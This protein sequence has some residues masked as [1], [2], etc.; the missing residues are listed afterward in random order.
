MRKIISAAAATLACV[1]AASAIDAQEWANYA[2]Y[3]S[4]NMSVEK[5]PVAVLMGDSITEGWFAQDPQFFMDNNFAGRGISGQVTPQMLLRFQRDVVELKPKFVVILAG[6]NDVARNSGAISPEDIMRNI[7]SMCEIA[8][9][10]KIRPVLCSVLP[11]CE[12]KWNPGIKDVAKQI[13]ELNALIKEYAKKNKI[14][15][16]DYHKEMADERG[17]LPPELSPDEVHPN[18]EGYKVMEGI[19]LKAL[20]KA[21]K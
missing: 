13:E 17:G 7:A 5:R 20:A 14:L 9:A 12:Y 11:A 15:Y 8:A 1:C 21:Q 2:R 16:V 10:N 3:E 4:D 6:T 19:L 18:L